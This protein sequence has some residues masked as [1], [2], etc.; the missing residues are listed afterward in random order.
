MVTQRTDP[1]RTR[2]AQVGSEEE[3][4]KKPR[5]TAAAATQ[6][7]RPGSTAA[8]ATQARRPG[9]TAAH[10]SDVGTQCSERQM[11][12]DLCFMGTGFVIQYRHGQSALF[13]QK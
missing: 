3:E 9:S 8:T 5:S 11:G 1:G 7:R 10:I 4:R 12:F 2:T 6:T 13:L